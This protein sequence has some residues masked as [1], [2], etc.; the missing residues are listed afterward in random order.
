MLRGVAPMLAIEARVLLARA[1]TQLG[2]V[3]LARAL[4]DEAAELVDGYA[5]AGRLPELVTDARARVDA[6]ALP[7]GVSAAPLTPAEL[8]ILRYLP[9][10][11]SFAEIADELYASRNTVKTQA[12]SVYRKLGVSSRTAA[13]GTA[14]AAGLLDR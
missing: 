9:T 7:L 2:E 12:L 10:H 13:V 14:R 5:D 8:R 4:L 11:V 3:P 6:V 1:L